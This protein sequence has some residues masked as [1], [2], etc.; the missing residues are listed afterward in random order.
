MHIISV[1]SHLDSSIIELNCPESAWKLARVLR[2]WADPSILQTYEIERR[3][4]AQELIA[5]DKIVSTA[6]D[7]GTA[8]QYKKC[9][10]LQAFRVI[11]FI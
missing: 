3:G 10:V 11:P 7:G 2:K 6:L 8:A 1:G 4:Y 5:L 9:V